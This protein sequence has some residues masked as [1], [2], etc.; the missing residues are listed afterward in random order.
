[1]SFFLSFLKLFLSFDFL[2]V[3]HSSP[4]SS[5]LSLNRRRSTL[6]WAPVAA[7]ASASSAAAERK[8]KNSSSSSNDGDDPASQIAAAAAEAAAAAAAAAGSDSDRGEAGGSGGGSG[9][10]RRG[11]D[12]AAGRV[13]AVLLAPDAGSA[14]FLKEWDLWREMGVTVVPVYVGESN[15]EDPGDTTALEAALFSALFGGP[16]GLRGLLSGGGGGSE[17]SGGNASSSSSSSSSVDPSE[18]A[19]L[20]AGLPRPVAAA[21]VRRL[22]SVE[23]VSSERVMFGSPYF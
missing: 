8:N 19:V 2:L 9:N 14:P 10:R 13:A 6:E 3:L 16:G 1:V 12:A 5:S 22:C 18:A 20:V 17:S 23:G 15:E 21:L 4:F 7:A 11:A